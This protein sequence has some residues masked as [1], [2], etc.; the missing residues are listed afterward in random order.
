MVDPE[1]YA[2]RVIDLHGGRDRL[3]AMMDERLRAFNE[4]WNQDAR[5]I[6]RVLR[7]HLA[8][9]HFL[10]EF[11]AGTNPRLG[12]LE[13]ARVTFSQKVELLPD[14]D[15]GV[16]F[17][18]PGLRRLNAIR[19]RIAHRLRVDVTA[20]DRDALLG[21]PLFAAMCKEIA[22]R[23]GAK[24]DDPLSVVEQFAMFA[25]NFLQAGAS[26]ER[27]LWRQA[28]QDQTGNGPAAS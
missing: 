4:V 14:D 15:P 9:E 17:L 27:D 10:T 5:S 7:A 26:P 11:V 21:I 3:S 25:A 24:P 28:A 20:E 18:K 19:N 8:A 13:E 22:R 6:G 12:P 23:D 2:A 16:S 1:R